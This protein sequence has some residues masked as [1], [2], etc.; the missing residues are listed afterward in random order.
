MSSENQPHSPGYDTTEPAARRM[1]EV[2]VLVTITLIILVPLFRSY[3]KHITESE[4]FAGEK[5]GS[6]GVRSRTEIQ[7]EQRARLESAPLSVNQA[8]KM[9]STAGRG[10]APA[11]APKASE[12]LGALEGWTLSKNE[13]AVQAAQRAVEAAAL[14]DREPAAGEEEAAP[15]E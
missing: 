9:L 15:A 2:A 5:I 8:A 7:A 3:F 1:L 13:K 10:G 14:R 6:V 12:D 11:V 4:L